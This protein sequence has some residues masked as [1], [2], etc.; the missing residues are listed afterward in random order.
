MSAAANFAWVNRSCI[1]YLARKAFSKVFKRNP[2][3]LDMHLIY[4]VCHNIA[5]IEKHIVDG[6]E[7][8]LCVHRKGSTR[9]F[10][11]HHPNLPDSYK[12]IGQPVLIGG[13]M[14]TC[15]YVL[16]GE[17]SCLYIFIYKSFFELILMTNN[18][19]RQR[20]VRDIWFHVSW[21]W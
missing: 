18:R 15:S 21:S 4:D 16:V 11:P 9:A 1:T 2:D 3:E 7:K 12:S 10:P 17:S 19:N 13:T 5:K 20:H 14:G 8:T 6:K